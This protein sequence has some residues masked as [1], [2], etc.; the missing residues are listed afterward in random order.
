MFEHIRNRIKTEVN[1]VVQQEASNS[2][3]PQER[4]EIMEN[5]QCIRGEVNR[6]ANILKEVR[7]NEENFALNC[8]KKQ[9]LEA[10]IANPDQVAQLQQQYPDY[11]T[12]LRDN[13]TALEGQLQQNVM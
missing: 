1:L 5:L 12:R 7:T 2:T 13:M 8:N 11:G 9:E 6:S 3:M 10:I 4:D